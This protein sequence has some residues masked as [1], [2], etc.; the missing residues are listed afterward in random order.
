MSRQDMF[1]RALASLHEAMFDDA[2]WPTASALI[3]DACGIKGSALVVGKGHSQEDS[4][5]LF[6][7]FCER[8]ERYENRERSYFNDYYPHDERVP[9]I[10]TLPD[11]R[12]AHIPDLY[13][14]RELKTSP[15]YNEL[16]PPTNC[17]NGLNVR[18]N[19]PDGSH[20]VWTLTDSTEP[21]GW[22]SAQTK[23]IE[24]LLPHIRQF[25]RVRQALVGAEVLGA[26]LTGLLDNTR[27]AVIYLDRRGSIAAANDRARS[28]LRQ[29]DGLFDRDGFLAAW[30]PAD[31]AQLKLLLSHAL[32]TDGGQAVSGSMT[33]R[34]SSGLPRLAVHVNPV[35]SRQMDF[36]TRRIAA[37]VW[38]LDPE[39]RPDIDPVLVASTLGLTP[40]ESRVAVLLAA[41]NSVRDIAAATGHQENS[42]RFHIEQIHRKHGTSRQA[43]LV[44]LVLSLANFSHFRP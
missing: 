3:D 8:G 12:L 43:D 6:G 16:L 40:V 9:R 24:H 15:T 13:T 34:R 41:G 7:R 14:E 35:E 44:H 31:N 22:G 33:V 17:Q 39:F 11:S 37:L 4:Q 38:V 5:I 25:V 2:H 28:I 21:S 30:L 32:P 10:V 36:N 26:S 1:N 18:L 27:V 29:G 20:I 19:G 42:V 23:V